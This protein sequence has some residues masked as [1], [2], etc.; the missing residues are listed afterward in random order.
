M[1][2]C[3][4]KKPRI[5]QYRIKKQDRSV[6]VQVRLKRDNLP[7]SSL[8]CGAIPPLSLFLVFPG[9]GELEFGLAGTSTKKQKAQNKSGGKAPHSKERTCQVAPCGWPRFTECPDLLNAARLAVRSSS[10]TSK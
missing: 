9:D 4:A 6:S 5:S 7:A 3:L 2:C 10:F 1:L 8:D